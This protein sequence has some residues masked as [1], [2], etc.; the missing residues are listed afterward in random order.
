MEDPTI[1]TQSA[2][3]VRYLYFVFLEPRLA[4]K[5]ANESIA[6][7]EVSQF[8][9]RLLLL[10]ESACYASASTFKKLLRHF[11]ANDLNEK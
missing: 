9:R 2:V 4:T 11:L 10:I 8:W 1:T 5:A 6:K 3:L 7:F